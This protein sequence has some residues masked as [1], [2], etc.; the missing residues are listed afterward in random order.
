MRILRKLLKVPALL[1][2]PLFSV[3]QW[4]GIFMTGLA[5]SILNLLA[6]LFAFTAGASYLMGLASGSEALKMMTIGFILFILP[7]IAEQIII[8]ITA[9][10]CGLM[11]FIRS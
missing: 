1:M 7:V 11:D 4:I 3:L 5:G 9:L 10:R 6:F 2:L 8:G